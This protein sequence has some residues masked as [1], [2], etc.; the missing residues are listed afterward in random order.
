MKVAV[1]GAVAQ[2]HLRRIIEQLQ[3]SRAIERFE[4]HDIDGYPDFSVWRGGSDRRILIVCKNARDEDYRK[5]GRVIGHKVETQKTRASRTD[6]SSRYYP[7][8]RSNVMAV[9]LGKKTGNW[10][11]FLF[12]KST[13][14]IRHPDY[15]DRLA[16]MQPVPLLSSPELGVWRSD[17]GE[18][19]ALL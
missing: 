6:L 11:D 17:L 12:A 18:V 3:A 14:L 9:C 16:V 2:V 7:V 19:I 5:A 8:T 1:E 15:S 4:E 13:D 10:S